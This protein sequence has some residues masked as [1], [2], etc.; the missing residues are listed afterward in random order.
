ML[1]HINRN[2]L[3]VLPFHRST[4]LFSR[5]SRISA[6]FSLCLLWS[7]VPGLA[8]KA[9]AP[10]I[11]ILPK[12]D[13]HTEIKTKGT[14]DEVKM[15]SVGTKKDIRE[16]VIKSGDETIHIYVCPKTFEDE[17]GISFAKG[18]EI[19]VTGSKVKQE[20]LDGILA[21]EMVR[22]GDTLVF[23]DDKGNPVWNSR[24]GK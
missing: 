9:A 23:R 18:E 19:A 16:L 24:T 11:I 3:R 17:M 15:F 22:G 13:L 1:L 7:A 21:R 2:I 10:D 4:I 14:V 20:T 6:A 5:T 12:Y 8:Q